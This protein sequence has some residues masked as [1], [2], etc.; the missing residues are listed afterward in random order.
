MVEYYNSATDDFEYF[1]E[2]DVAFKF[3]TLVNQ[4]LDLNETQCEWICNNSDKIN[5]YL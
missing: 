5:T 3:E 1:N 2:T 4:T